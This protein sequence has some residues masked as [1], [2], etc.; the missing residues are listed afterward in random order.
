MTNKTRKD[1]RGRSGTS[2][3]MAVARAHP[4]LTAALLGCMMA[5]S[6]LAWFFLPAEI[7]DLRRI[8]G[9]ALLGLLSWLLAMMGRLLD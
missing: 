6:F 5:G 3:L 7:S 4:V 2:T 9:G 1:E 8:L